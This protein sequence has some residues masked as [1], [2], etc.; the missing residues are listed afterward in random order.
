MAT[1]DLDELPM[2]LPIAFKL[3]KNR[4]HKLGG[5][6]IRMAD[7]TNVKAYRMRRPATRSCLPP[8]S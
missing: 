3:L 4:R 6:T 8:T 5:I 2:S 7:L 1:R